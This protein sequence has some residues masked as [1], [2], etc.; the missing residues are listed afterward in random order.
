MFLNYNSQQQQQEWI[1]SAPGLLSLFRFTHAGAILGPTLKV[2]PEE[3]KATITTFA[4]I[5][6]RIYKMGR[7]SKISL[8]ICTPSYIQM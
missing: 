3:A 8:N 7:G 2:N 1:W 6:L 5:F 4:H